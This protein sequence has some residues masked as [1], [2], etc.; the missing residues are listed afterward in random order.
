MP[1]NFIKYFSTGLALSL[2]VAL[3]AQEQ[4]VVRLANDQLELGWKKGAG[5]YALETLKVKG[6]DGWDVMETAKYQHNVL[7]AS[8]KPETTP[9]KLYDKTG[10][11]ILFPAPQYRYIIPS[12]QQN[13]NAVAMNKAGENLVYQPSAVKR[14]SDT[15]ICFYYE[16][17]TM[18]ITEKWCLDS[19]HQ[20]DIKVDFIVYPRKAGYYSLATPSLVSIDKY[21]FQWATVPG[22]FQGNAINTDFVQAYGYGQGIPDVPVVTRERTA[23]TLSSLVTDKKGVTVAVTA[24]PGTGRDPWPEDKKMHAEWLLGL[25]VMNREGEFSPTLY[26]PVLG[27]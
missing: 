17:E 5:G 16:N 3:S 15:E 26:H 4:S 2:S 12:W 25:S 19:F 24:E 18:R 7:Y 21:N 14:I 13:T 10:K 11:G 8:S 22:I 23:S 27:S 1:K 6:T 9:Q 20:N